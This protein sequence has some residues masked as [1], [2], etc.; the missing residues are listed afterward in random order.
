ME[1][2]KAAQQKR[3]KLLVAA[4]LVLHFNGPSINAFLIARSQT[5]EFALNC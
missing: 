3:R 1:S 5:A 2:S 4:A